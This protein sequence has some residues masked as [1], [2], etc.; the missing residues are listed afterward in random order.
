MNLFKW[1][2]RNCQGLVHY[3][4]SWLVGLR[5][6]A[7][8]FRKTINQT[9]AIPVEPFKIIWLI[10]FSCITIASNAT[11][12]NTHI[13]TTTIHL[14]QLNAK[15][16]NLKTTLTYTQQQKQN[17]QQSLL[18][19]EQKLQENQQ[20]L[21]AIQQELV[22]IQHAIDTLN[23]QIANLT[24]QH[25]L[26]QQQLA[27]QA[28][29]L[30]K[31][32]TRKNWLQPIAN[33]QHQQMQQYVKYFIQSNQKLSKSLSNSQL[34]LDEKMHALQQA[35][36]TKT[37]LQQTYTQNRQELIRNKNTLVLDL[38]KSEYNIKQM[39]QKLTAYKHDQN[40]LTQLL[41]TLTT[42]SVIQTRHSFTHMQKKL[43]YPLHIS[44]LTKKNLQHGIWFMAPANTPVY[45]IFPGE[46]IFA[47]WLNGYGYLMILDHG[48]GFMTLYAYNQSLLKHIGDTVSTQDQ[49]AIVGHTGIFK[50]YGLYFEIR[51]H[52]KPIAPLTWLSFVSPD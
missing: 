9:L 24:Q 44:N 8:Y 18:T 15:I 46:V 20:K 7:L 10:S 37:V 19:S 29:I 45:A 51:H 14:K 13:N 42:Q 30:Y 40:N 43:P 25:K 6:P 28:R 27:Q 3:F 49:I 17:S 38:A 35:I 4:T 12:N 2:Y 31:L 11:S 48:W 34:Q 41:H 26:Q 52:G 23:L 5:P 21:N 33:V 16:Q 32:T 50:Q 36:Q 22:N 39:Q 47:N 1:L